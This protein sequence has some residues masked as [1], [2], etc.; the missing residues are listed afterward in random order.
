M[1]PSPRTTCG[2]TCSIGWAWS[3]FPF[4]PC[5][6]QRGHRSAGAPFP[7]QAQPGAEPQG[8]RSSPATCWPC[9][10]NMTGP[11]TFVNWNM[12]S[13]GPSI[14][15]VSSRTIERRHL[16][17][18]LTT[19]RRLRGQ[20]DAIQPP[21]AGS[22]SAGADL[23]GGLR[24][25]ERRS[26]GSAGA[27]RPPVDGGKGLLASQA[28]H[29]KVVVADA[30]A[31]HRGNVTRAAASIGI[32]RQLFTYKMKKYRIDRRDYLND[33]ILGKPILGPLNLIFTTNPEKNTEIKHGWHER[34]QPQPMVLFRGH[35]RGFR[36][37]GLCLFT[38]Q[39]HRIRQS[40]GGGTT[41]ARPGRRAMPQG[42]VPITIIFC[43]WCPEQEVF[44]GKA[45]RWEFQN[46]R[47]PASGITTWPPPSFT[48][49]VP[50]PN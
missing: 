48:R 24:L 10:T 40:A 9:S 37:H 15:V 28:D 46:G 49:T 8:G 22:S 27:D 42:P 39:P 13:K 16:Q 2:P 41:G 36:R 3:S 32:S 31:A 12:S 6:T 17:S 50:F 20:P 25:R 33:K 34:N 44:S 35:R 19:W 47:P 5:G 43:P 45:V 11:A 23:Y 30:L 7:G 38:G 29:E 26:A 1:W 14:M 4:L 18:H 21:V